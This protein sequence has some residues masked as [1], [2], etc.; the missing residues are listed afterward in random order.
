MSAPDRLQVVLLQAL[1]D[2]PAY[3]GFLAD[4]ARMVGEPEAA[5]EAAASA[6]EQKGLAG[7]RNGYAS[8]TAAAMEFDALWPGAV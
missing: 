6:L 1:L 7:V 3:G 2:P 8:A 4:L 5:V